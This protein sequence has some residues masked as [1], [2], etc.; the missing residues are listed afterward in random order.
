MRQVQI[1]GIHEW[2]V[3]G[4]SPSTGVADLQPREAWLTGVGLGFIVFLGV[5]VVVWYGTGGETAAAGILGAT[6]PAIAAIVSAVIG[7]A[8]GAKTGAAA[9]TQAAQQTKKTAA[10]AVKKAKETVDVA[11]K[12]RRDELTGRAADTLSVARAGPSSTDDLQRKLE[13]A[14]TRLDAV[15]DSLEE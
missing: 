14:S 12:A 7:V 15:L 13:D 5:F 6:I 2:D 8:M 9:G 3:S 10:A 11:S 4:T 1:A